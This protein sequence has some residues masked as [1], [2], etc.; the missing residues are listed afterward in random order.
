MEHASSGSLGIAIITG[1][2]AFIGALISHLLTQR[3]SLDLAIY[4][5]RGEAYK[6]LWERTFLLPRWPQRAGVTY[7]QLRTL[8]E[9]LRH[10]YYFVGGVYL[11]DSARNAYGDLQESLND[12]AW[13]T[14]SD[15]LSAPHYTLLMNLCSKV[16]TELTH[17][18]LS[19]K[20]M[21]LF[22][23]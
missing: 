21:F 11:S 23:R 22:S 18:L 2:G 6:G 12:P 7:A 16:R 15:P 19:R 3:R 17:D 14:S 13:K 1:V 9:E 20:R 10:W 4:K 8:S 5:H